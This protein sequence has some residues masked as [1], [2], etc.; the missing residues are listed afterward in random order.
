MPTKRKAAVRTPKVA[1]EVLRRWLEMAEGES[2]ALAE[3]LRATLTPLFAKTVK[4]P[5]VAVVDFV[6]LGREILGARFVTPDVM[7]GAW[8][9]KVTSM[10]R[11]GGVEGTMEAVELLNYCA[12]WMKGPYLADSIAG[13]SGAWLAM[14]RAQNKPTT[15]GDQ[16]NRAPM[17]LEV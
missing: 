8:F 10:L 4:R 17:E 11:N 1:A 3:D 5:V 2:G 6:A 9:A 15:T 14:A 16:R 7:T 13:R 12:T